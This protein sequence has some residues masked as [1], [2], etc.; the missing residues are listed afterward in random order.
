MADLS[1]KKSPVSIAPQLRV[2]RRLS[3][4]RPVEKSAHEKALKEFVDS[5]QIEDPFNASYGVAT[6]SE[7]TLFKPP[8]NMGSLLRLPRENDMLSQCIAAM[9]T[10]VAG[11]GFGLEYI[12]PDGQKDSA[13]SK[14]ERARLEGLLNF[15]NEDATLREVIEREK[16]DKETLGMGYF[17]IGR[18]ED[19][20][21]SMISHLPAHTMRITQRDEQPTSY[22][23]MLPRNGKMEAVT[24][25]KRF[26]RY[27]QING[28]DKRYFKEFGDNRKISP[29]TG[30]VDNSLA[31]ADSATEV[32]FDPI[33][34]PG[35]VYGLPR[36][37][38]QLPSIMGSREAELV[39]LAFFRENAIPAM[40]M[41][42]SG[43]FLT[44]DA[45]ESIENHFAGVRGRDSMNR[46]VVLEVEADNRMASAEGTLTVPKVD[47]KALQGERQDDAL[48][49]KYGEAAQ[50]KIRSS[51]RLPPVF[52]GGSSDYTY[53]SAKVSFE[54]AESQIFGP[55]RAQTDDIFNNKI[56]ASYK[57]KFWAFKLQ[58]PKITDPAEVIAAITAFDEAGGMTMNTVIAMANDYFN[59]DMPTVT[60]EWG[61][62]PFAIV[63]QLAING[64]LKGMDVIAD[65]TQATVVAAQPGSGKPPSNGGTPKKEEF[66]RRR[67]RSVQP[68]A[69]KE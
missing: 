32:I 66:I 38:S 59:L 6:A 22:T 15:P 5:K 58:P 36:W 47:L 69:N 67:T 54:V 50:N 44:A 68:V 7:L 4:V 60:D 16:N 14:K 29:L 8:Y 62:W 28:S 21:V 46:I 39:N 52:V 2:R 48:F 42:I 27:V 31:F 12:G 56:L 64:S 1:A 43:G 13:A 19:N 40:A 3:L 25:Q 57:P 53:A 51:F 17:E 41:L 18:G 45:I 61:D 65:V 34:A 63:K 9:V 23:I 55:E 33:Y 10:N 11:H 37:L 20:L 30:K 35:E 24:I 26:R 49:L